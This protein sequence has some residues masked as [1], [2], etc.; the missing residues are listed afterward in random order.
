MK[1]KKYYTLRFKHEFLLKWVG[2][3]FQT[4]QWNFMFSLRKLRRTRE[5][6][7]PGWNEYETSFEL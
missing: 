5:L 1:K 3:T 4:K 7:D 2:Q 6:S